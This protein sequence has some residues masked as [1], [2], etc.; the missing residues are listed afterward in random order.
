MPGRKL[1]AFTAVLVLAAVL[2][3]PAA[4]A[5]DTN[6][7]PI[8]SALFWTS[9]NVG[10]QSYGWSIGDGSGGDVYPVSWGGQTCIKMQPDSAYETMAYD[11]WGGVCELDGYLPISAGD[12][13][14]WS[15]WIWTGASST[16]DTSANHGAI[17]GCDM[18]GSGA[19]YTGRIQEVDDVGGVGVPDYNGA[20]Y[21]Y[22]KD[23]W[24]PWGSGGWVHDSMTVTVASTYI[25]DGFNGAVGSGTGGAPLGTVMTPTMI[26]PWICTETSKGSSS[27]TGVAYIYGTELYV[28]PSGSAVSTPAPTQGGGSGGS[29]GW[30]VINP[31]ASP[32]PTSTAKGLSLQ[33]VADAWNSIGGGGK[34]F[35]LVAVGAVA[36]IFAGKKR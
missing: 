18:Y 10:G 30:S 6:L 21:S 11:S 9:V 23:G 3:A 13:V 35:L 25:S 20:S 27:E 29:G 4:R 34:L 31:T 12:V 24:V 15:V 26:C 14:S 32:S 28:N 5:D 22:V 8:P 1:L 16:G 33:S 7:A 36:F 2:A 17:F 19:G